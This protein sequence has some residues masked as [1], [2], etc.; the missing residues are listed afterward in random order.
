MRYYVT[1]ENVW[2]ALTCVRNILT[3]QEAAV[4]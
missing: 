4:Q 3:V 2:Y 1:V